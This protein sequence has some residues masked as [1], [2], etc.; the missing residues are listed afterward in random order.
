VGL[1][2]YNDQRL[3]EFVAPSLTCVVQPT[4]EMGR[5]AMAQLLGM[6]QGAV[7]DAPPVLAP[8]LIVRASCG[9]V[10]GGA[11]PSEG[12]DAPATACKEETR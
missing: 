1:V 6:L 10:E 5:V 7:L 3:A 4:R 2:V 8:E 11:R 9:C 12:S